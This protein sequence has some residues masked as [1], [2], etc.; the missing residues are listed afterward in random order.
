MPVIAQMNFLSIAALLA[1]A[2]QRLV[3]NVDLW[4]VGA[5]DAPSHVQAAGWRFRPR[6]R[7][8]A[9]SAGWPA[10]LTQ[11]RLGHQMVASWLALAWPFLAAGELPIDRAR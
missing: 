5:V 3:T 10:V 7:A 4:R 9:E 11:L 1:K 8:L 6:S 2:G